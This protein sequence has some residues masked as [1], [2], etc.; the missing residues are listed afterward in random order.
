MTRRATARLAVALATTAAGFLLALLA[1]SPEAAVLVAPWAVLL[2]LGVTAS[3]GTPPVVSVAVEQ[4]RV[5]V[6]DD[7]DVMTSVEEATGSVTVTVTP[8]DAFW[9]TTSDG[10]RRFGRV[11]EA[12]I[13]ETTTVHQQLP[14]TQWGLHDVGRVHFTVTEPYGLLRWRGSAGRPHTV[15]VHPTPTQLRTLLAPWLVRR[16][17]GTHGSRVVGR[18]VEFVDVRPF[19]SGD[20][21]R[22]INWKVTARANELWVSQRHPDR[23]SDVML[24]VDS[25]VESGHDVR[26][27]VGVAIEAA[28]ALAES[29]LAVTDRVGI[30]ELGGMVRWVRPGAGQLQLQRLVDALLAT[31][32]HRHVADRDLAPL[33]SRALPPRSFVVALSPLLDP[34]FID[35]LFILGGHGHDVAVVECESV[36]KLAEHAGVNQRLAERI[37]QAE[38]QMVRDRLAD[39]GIAVTRWR[40]GVHL[41]LALG[42]LIRRRRRVIHGARR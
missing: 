30:V 4:E 21:L 36:T 15:R 24:L 13:G 35:A 22:E 27:V 12:L 37:W 8:G 20:S 26:T 14:A 39:R 5:V 19:A 1:G 16:V 34:R 3:R 31:G 9:S 6:G 41:D 18:G 32:L 2:L 7:I 38:R 25:F 11:S 42:D 28:V 17:T 33:L 40:R 23:A 10:E 29:H